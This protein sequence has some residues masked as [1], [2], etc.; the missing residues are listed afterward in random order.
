M[1]R[2]E[3][4]RPVTIALWLIAEI[5]VIASDIP[6]VIGT[7]IALKILFGLKLWIGVLVT[8]T[9]ALAFLALSFFGVRKVEVAITLLLGMM[10]SV[11]VPVSM[12]CTFYACPLASR[13]HL[14]IHHASVRP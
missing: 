7:A 9:A 3:Y 12:W 1:C 2:S 11:R 14:S 10:G 13:F 4:P 5:T 6:E 8:S